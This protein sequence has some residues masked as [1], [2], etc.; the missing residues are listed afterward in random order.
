MLL[1]KFNAGD[2]LD[3]HPLLGPL[4]FFL[5]MIFVVF[6]G[7]TMFVAIINMG[8]HVAYENLD[9]RGEDEEVIPALMS[10]FM[11]WTGKWKT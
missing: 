11:R 7:V 2:L 3:A 4:I 8:Y 9:V 1:M 10:K 5:F 6:I